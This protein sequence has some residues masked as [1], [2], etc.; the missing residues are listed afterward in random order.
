MPTK[1]PSTHVFHRGTASY[2]CGIK[3]SDVISRTYSDSRRFKN[4]MFPLCRS[5]AKMVDIH[6]LNHI[7]L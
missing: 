4:L 1:K 5:C 7:D 3:E 6:F 2:I